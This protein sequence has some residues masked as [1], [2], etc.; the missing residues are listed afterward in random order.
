MPAPGRDR[1]PMTAQSAF[2]A[3]PVVA[4]NLWA[5]I[6]NRPL[7]RFYLT[8]TWGI[9]SPWDAGEAVRSAGLASA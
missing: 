7:R 1:A 8:I 4:H 2:Q 5:A 3:A 9:C 6:Q